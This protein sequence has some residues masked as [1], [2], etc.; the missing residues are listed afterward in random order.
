MTTT[1]NTSA[2][3][4]EDID[5]ALRW[6]TFN[7]KILPKKG[8]KYAEPTI[9]ESLRAKIVAIEEEMNAKVFEREDVIHGCWIA[10][11]A[12]Q[13]VVMVGPGGTG[14]SYLA[15]VFRSHISNG[16]WFETALDET[17]DPNDTFGPP[18]VKAMAELGITRRI[19]DGML[20]C[21]TEAFI[22][23][24]MN[25]NTPMMHSLMPPLNER[26]F[27]TGGKAYKIPLR[28]MISG[29]NK[30]TF[31]PD[32]A[33]FFDRLHQRHVVGYIKDRTNQMK[34]VYGSLLR[35][36]ELG[37]G[38]DVTMAADQPTTVTLEELDQANKESLSLN[39]PDHVAHAFFD[40]RDQIML[41]EAKSEVSDRRAAETFL[42]VLANAWLR[43]H[44][45]V[46]LGDLDILAAMWWSQFEQRIQVRNAVLAVTNPGERMAYI[47]NDEFEEV[48]AETKDQLAAPELDDRRKR[49]IIVEATVRVKA[50]NNNAENHLAET[51]AVGMP[52][53]R[54]EALIARLKQYNDDILQE[55]FGI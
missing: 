8:S 41:G 45:E 18:D 53:A 17:S 19:P 15:R 30:L 27:M 13:H 42:A 23:E 14:K 24:I 5:A 22:D 52:T 6:I 16:V 11:V 25:A 47:L 2:A 7:E 26:L 43:G 46:Q 21:C 39:V 51:R 20:P 29:T 33:A 1:L 44:E 48:Q 50:I 9:T 54:L 37:R 4:L 38:G 55:N 36:A 40:L 35:N 31:E 32:Q 10:R 34:M 28:M 12:H 3:D 49:D